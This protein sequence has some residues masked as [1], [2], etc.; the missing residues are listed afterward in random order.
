MRNLGH[1]INQIGFEDTQKPPSLLGVAEIEN[2]FVL[3]QLIDSEYLKN[4]NYKFA[5][6]DSRDERGIDTALLYNADCFEIFE[7][8][9]HE[10]YLKKE[11]GTQD[12]TRDV[13][14]VKGRLEGEIVDIL[15]NHWPS[16]RA[17]E[18]LTEYSRLIA[19]SKNVEIITAIRNTNSNAKIIVLGD[20][21]DDPKSE[22]IKT[23]SGLNVYNPMEL[24]LTKEDGSLIFQ[25]KWKLF[26]QIIMSKFPSKL[27]K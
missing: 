19:A 22:S 4:T 17:G 9:T 21:K 20:F 26:D 23:I 12:Y 18:K 25:G 2:A 27:W 24:L 5:H 11:D 16:R 10:V 3:Q 15:V 8:R 14:H 1:I 6:V 7:T 13:L